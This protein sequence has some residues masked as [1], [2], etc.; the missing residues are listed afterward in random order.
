MN[1][2]CGA[3]D[4]LEADYEALARRL[5]AATWLSYVGEEEGETAED[6]AAVRAE[7]G[8]LFDRARPVLDAC[9]GSGGDPIIA[10]RAEVWRRCEGAW[11]LDAD[12][13]AVRLRTDLER[14]VNEHAFVR[15]DRTWSRS[16]LSR[17]SRSDDPAERRLV[18]ELRGDLHGEV[19]EDTLRLVS[20]R[21]EAAAGLGGAGT[22]ADA[23][24]GAEGLPPELL[25][26]LLRELDERTAEAW[27]EV[28]RRGREAGGDP[29]ATLAPW[30]VPW[31]IEKLGTIPDERW[32]KEQA[33]PALSE[34]LRGIGVELE[35]LPI[36]RREGD[37][38]YGGQTLAVSI[39]DDVRMMINPLPGW[40]VWGTLFHETGHALQGVSTTVASPILKGYEW[41]AGASVPAYAEGMAELLGL[42]VGDRAF[43]ERRTDL[44]TEEI[45]RFLALWRARSLVSVRSRLAD[46][47]LERALY[48]EG[49]DVDAVE[50]EVAER[51]LGLALPLDA[52]ATWAA[53]AFLA[54]YP[55]YMQNYVLADLIAAQV[56]RAVRERFGEGWLDDPAV[57]AFLR[58]AL[59]SDGETREWT[60][61]VR[62]ATGEELSVEAYLEF[63]MGT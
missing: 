27:A 15:G 59:W 36:R 9:R 30:D 40:R 38:G 4:A 6:P 13:E 48:E 14:R 54:A 28:L 20:L 11:R 50:H 51:Y 55:C 63:V 2:S 17:L 44:S 58:E 39:P 18:V 46:V 33:L 43:L 61:R 29:A 57:G 12:P 34:T 1:D 3:L 41:L 26:P 37:F 8:R 49:T 19:L 23:M 56:L 25:D 31:L 62:E 42:L 16:D 52:P 60:V 10:R 5:G 22:Y 45:E 21:K 32:P 7:F 24:L 53:T 47:A 35:A